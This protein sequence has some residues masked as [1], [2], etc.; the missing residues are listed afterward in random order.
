MGSTPIR[1]TKLKNPFFKFFFIIIYVTWK[2]I[3]YINFFIFYISAKQIF[4]LSNFF[5]NALNICK[6]FLIVF[7]VRVRN[8]FCF[9]G[10]W[11]FQKTKMPAS[12]INQLDLLIKNFPKRFFLALR[13]L[14]PLRRPKIFFRQIFVPAQ[15]FHLYSIRFNFRLKIFL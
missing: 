13:F 14:K 11:L 8:Y 6:F 3:I 12:I 1:R 10:I 9:Y 15:L 5:F 4:T 2:T 7:L